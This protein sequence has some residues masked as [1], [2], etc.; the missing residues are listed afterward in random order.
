MVLTFNL[1]TG[2]Q[3]D[4]LSFL[5]PQH[6]QAKLNAMKSHILMLNKQ[7]VEKI[8]LKKFNFSISE[9]SEKSVR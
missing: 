8:S 3:I 6:L 4:G 2:V 1:F 5:T 9:K 7:N